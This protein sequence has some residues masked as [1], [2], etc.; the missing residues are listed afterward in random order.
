[1]LFGIA[2]CDV[3]RFDSEYGVTML[4][5]IFWHV[6]FAD[7]DVR[8]YESALLGFHTD[9]VA[10]SPPGFKASSTY[11]ISEVPWLN[12]RPGYEDWCFLTSSAALDALNEAAIRPERWNVHA[13]I[14]SK[15]DFGHGGL[16]YHLHGAEQPI[17]GSRVIWLKRPRGI[18]YEQ[19]LRDIVGESK[20]FLSCWRKQ[21]VLGP[22]DEFA[23]IGNSSLVVSVPQGWQIRVVERR[24]L[25]PAL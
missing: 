8:E 23:I 14:A 24:F 25:G 6:P 3:F 5:Y 20:G 16:Y 15:T 12:G 13:A 17:V 19:A 2:V 22:A 7:I 10:S 9:L 11:Q 21:M 1:L 4:A 18:R